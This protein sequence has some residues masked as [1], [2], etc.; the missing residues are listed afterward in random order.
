FRSLRDILSPLEVILH[1]NYNSIKQASQAPLKERSYVRQKLIYLQQD[2]NYISIVPVMK[3][4]EIEVPTYSKKQL[5]DTDRNGNV[6]QIH[7]NYAEEDK[8]LSSIMDKI[9]RAHV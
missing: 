9:G 3:Y 6:F 2:G 1:I 7:R 5:F 8:L 4:G